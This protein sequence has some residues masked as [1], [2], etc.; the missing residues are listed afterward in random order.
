MVFPND[1]EGLARHP[2]QLYQFALEGVLLFILVYS[3]SR[4]PRPTGAV[5]GVFLIGYSVA[6]LLVEFVR[7]P[8]QHIQYDLFGWVTRG[9]ILSLPMLLLGLAL[10]LWAY[11]GPLRKPASG[12]TSS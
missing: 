4:K 5:T 1:P 3:F 7:E 6:R 2:S 11:F 12:G 10:V 9:Q 8:D